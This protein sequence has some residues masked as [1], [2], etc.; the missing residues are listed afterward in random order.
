MVGKEEDLLILFHQ[1]IQCLRNKVGELEVYIDSQKDR[2]DVICLTEHWMTEEEI[3]FIKIQGYQLKSFFTRKERQHGGSCIFVNDNLKFDSVQEIE[4]LSV[5]YQLECACVKSKGRKIIILCVYRTNLGDFDVFLRALEDILSQVKTKYKFYKTVLCG[6]FNVNLM[7]TNTNKSR[8]LDLILTFNLNQTVFEP[9]RVT[10]NT[11]SLIDGFFINFE[12]TDG[13]AV[14]TA[15]SDHHGQYLKF[16]ESAESTMQIKPVPKRIFSRVKVEQYRIELLNECWMDVMGMSEANVAYDTFLGRL[17][18]VLNR[19]ITKRRP[20]PENNKTKPW[21]TP[22]IRKSCATKRDLYSGML[23]NMVSEKYYRTY[24]NILK[25]IIKQAKLLSSTNFIIEAENKGKATWS[26]INNIVKGKQEKGN[27]FDNFKNRYNNENDLLDSIN[28]YF[29]ESCPDTRK[30]LEPDYAQ[31]KYSE[32]SIFLEAVTEPEVI[33]CINSLK[34]KKSVGE[35]EL[36]VSLL[37]KV[38]DIIAEPLTHIINICFQTGTFPSKLKIAHIK[39]IY[40]KKGDIDNLKN[41]RPISLLSNLSKIFEKMIYERFIR[42]LDGRGIMSDSQYG[43]RRGRSTVKATYET[44]KKTL[45]SINQKKNTVAVLMD[46][47]KAFDSVDH[48]ILLEKLDRYGIRGVA[49]KL[50]STYLTGRVQCVVDTNERGEIIKSNYCLITKGVP[51]GSIIGPLLYILYTNELPSL[52][53]DQLVMYADDTSIV[54]SEENDVQEHLTDSV[55]ILQDWFTRNNLLMNIEKTQLIQFRSSIKEES[56]YIINNVKID[57]SKSVSFLGVTIDHRLDWK[58]QVDGLVS[59]LSKYCYA[60]R[61]IAGEVGQL[62]ALNAYHAYVVSRFRYGI[63]FWGNSSDVLRVQ[64]LQKRCVR[65]ICGLRFRESCRSV[66]KDMKLFT[67]VGLYVYES[68]KFILQNKTLFQSNV[69]VHGYDTRHGDDFLLDRTK[70]SFVQRNVHY[71][72]LK[73]W[74]HVPSDLRSLKERVF[75]RTVKNALLNNP[76]YSVREYFS[77]SFNS[78]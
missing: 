70:Y 58:T 35:D 20:K 68:I 60:L 74:N 1:N 19:V 7:G 17:Q 61:V 27:I 51:Q 78:C 18:N 56:S 44:L 45:D 22:G 11:S 62:C 16:Q 50:I 5:E 76:F 13:S 31:L 29:I 37:K 25:K 40:K 2:P 36:P 28:N 21:I 14:V 24:C 55:N 26:I 75:L 65:A 9:T 64:V 8:F 46:L 23:D 53:K 67:V 72:L 42:Y 15:L 39:P 73:I 12:Y 43:F 30:Q 71:S 33:K 41:Y 47:S 48:S 4:L 54:I 32:T 69:K 49:K 6:D 57:T 59:D 38:A 3:K 63:I 66:F 34:N 77:F 52:V 10:K